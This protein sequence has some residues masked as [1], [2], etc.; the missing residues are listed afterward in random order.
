MALLDALPLIGV[1]TLLV[2]WSIYQFIFGDVRVG[3][4]L[5]VLFGVHEILRQIT[6]PKII[7]KSLGIHPVLSLI[8]LYVGYSIFGFFGLLLIPIAAV[9]VNTI[10]SN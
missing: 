2:P 10:K 9:V 3:V 6:E 1:G 7:G 4:G 8:L 5:L